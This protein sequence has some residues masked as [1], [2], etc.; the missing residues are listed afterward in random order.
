MESVRLRLS[1]D[2][3]QRKLN[4]PTMQQ[5]TLKHFQLLITNIKT[6]FSVGGNNAANIK[7]GVFSCAAFITLANFINVLESG[8]YSHFSFYCCGTDHLFLSVHLKKYNNVLFDNSVFYLGS[9]CYWCNNGTAFRS[10]KL[11]PRYLVLNTN[12]LNII[13]TNSFVFW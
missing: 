13:L 1:K 10:S 9:Y 2:Y 6:L 11:L 5:L 3:K 12:E 4:A 8:L 7:C